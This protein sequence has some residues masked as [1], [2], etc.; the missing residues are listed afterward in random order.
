MRSFLIIWGGGRLLNPMT[1]VL[2]KDT[3]RSET[4]REENGT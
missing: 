2:I 4:E 1:S 3:Q